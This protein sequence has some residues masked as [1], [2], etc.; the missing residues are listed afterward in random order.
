VIE[1]GAHEVVQWVAYLCFMSWR[2]G[3]AHW[4]WGPGITWEYLAHVWWVGTAVLKVTLVILAI[5]CLWLTLWA[6]QLRKASGGRAG[7]STRGEP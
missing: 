1:A 6:R 5:P 2:P 7:F 4:L 3:W